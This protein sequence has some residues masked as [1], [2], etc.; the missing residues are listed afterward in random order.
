MTCLRSHSYL[1]IGSKA[2]RERL[3]RPQATPVTRVI[4]EPVITCDM[5]GFKS[6]SPSRNGPFPGP[7]PYLPPRGPRLYCSPVALLSQPH[8]V[9]PHSQTCS[10]FSKRGELRRR[11]LFR[12][13]QAEARHAPLLGRAHVSLCLLTTS[14]RGK[15]DPPHFNPRGHSSWERRKATCL[16][17]R[18]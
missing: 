10:S 4:Q 12:S 16:S 9:L 18:R 6:R 3:L 11:Q 1:E 7:P 5:Y 13:Y 15:H 14:P 2:S 17:D 8:N